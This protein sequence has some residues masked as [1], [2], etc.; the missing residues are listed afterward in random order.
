MDKETQEQ[1]GE[2]YVESELAWLRKVI[3]DAICDMLDPCCRDCGWLDW[4]KFE[5]VELRKRER[6]FRRLAN[7]PDLDTFEEWRCDDALTLQ[8]WHEEEEKRF[9]R[10]LKKAAL[11]S[12]I[13]ESVV[14][15]EED[16]E[17]EAD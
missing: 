1:L 10:I 17:N 15:S 16:E 11:Q 3:I 4:I 9:L 14:S 8:E 12:E 5:I 7:L 13:D 2:H 6:L